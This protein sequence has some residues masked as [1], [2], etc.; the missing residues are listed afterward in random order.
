MPSFLVLAQNE[1][2]HV[3]LSLQNAWALGAKAGVNISSVRGEFPPNY[4]VESKNAIYMG[5]LFHKLLSGHIALN[6][7]L[8]Y[9]SQGYIER[10]ND[11]A[12]G[13]YSMKM[14]IGYLNMP[15][16]LQYITS[17][18]LSVQTGPQVSLLL[19]NDSYDING[20]DIGWAGGV[21]F[22]SKDGFGL[23]ASYLVGFSNIMGDNYYYYPST[24]AYNIKQ[25]VFQAGLVYYFAIVKKRPPRR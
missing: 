16:Q 8:Y 22:I 6:P 19:V 2:E 1:K 18:G 13:N 7:A 10:H 5:F 17:T 21:S 24:S 9:S 15:L 20:I 25:Q 12:W 11:P 4:T 23:E 3:L 14:N